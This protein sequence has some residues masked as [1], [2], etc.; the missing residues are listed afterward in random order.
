[1]LKKIVGDARDRCGSG[2]HVDLADGD[3]D[4]DVTKLSADERPC[5]GSDGEMKGITELCDDT[6]YSAEGRSLGC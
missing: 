2:N 3:E 6:V 4:G 1:M 5:T